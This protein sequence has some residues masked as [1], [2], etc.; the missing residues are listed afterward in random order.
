MPWLLTSSALL[1]LWPPDLP[2]PQEATRERVQ[3]A[4]R[5]VLSSREYDS[6][7]STVAGSATMNGWWLVQ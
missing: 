1:L 6:V 7:G 3:E 5:D 4:V 2:G